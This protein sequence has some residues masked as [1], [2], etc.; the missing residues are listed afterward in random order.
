MF[1]KATKSA[2]RLRAALCGTSGSG[3]TYSGLAIASALGKR[4]AVIDTEHGSAAKY[5]DIFEFDVLNLDSFEAEKF[6]EGIRAAERAGYDVIVIDS[7]SHAWMGTG[8]TLDQVTE[9]KRRSKNEFTAW[10]DPSK[11]HTELIEAILHARLHVIATM[12]SKTEYILEESQGRKVPRKVGMAPVQRDGMEY[13]FDVVGDMHDGT[14][15]ISKSRCPALSGKSFHHPGR[16]FGETLLAWLGTGPLPE[17]ATPAP[18]CDHPADLRERFQAICEATGTDPAVAVAALKTAAGVAK[19]SE[20]PAANIESWMEP[21]TPADA[22]DAA[23]WDPNYGQDEIG[24]GD[25]WEPGTPITDAAPITSQDPVWSRLITAAKDAGLNFT[26]ECAALMDAH[27]VLD[28]S[29]VPVEAVEARIA[30][31]TAAASAAGSAA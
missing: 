10:R 21:A 5:S 2:S 19:W 11:A 22:D 30:Q 3:K 8:G 12:R 29:G 15:V 20:I 17:P 24:E 26:K 9:A 16:E 25:H 23:P 7:L 14:L 28:C 4:I 13:E 1:T 18:L 6:T 31:I 27:G